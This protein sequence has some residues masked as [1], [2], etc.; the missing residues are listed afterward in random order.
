MENTGIRKLISDLNE[1]Q[2]EL[3][4]LYQI[5]EILKG[6][7]DSFSE[8]L[9]KVVEVLPNGYRFPEV[10]KTQIVVN[11][12]VIQSDGFRVTEL[13]QSAKIVFEGSVIGEVSVFFI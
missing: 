2:K 4:C 13:K 5:S 8:A 3:N 6:G 10:C 12:M 11:D 7:D 1:R 9:T